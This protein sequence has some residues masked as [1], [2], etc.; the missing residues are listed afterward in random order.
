MAEDTK[1]TVG[2]PMNPAGMNDNI[3]LELEP[4]WYQTRGVHSLA[5]KC[6][7]RCNG[8]ELLNKFDS[9]ILAIHGGQRERVFVE[10]TNALYM[11]DNIADTLPIFIMGDF[12]EPLLG[13]DDLPLIE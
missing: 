11:F 8:K 2:V 1:A 9:P 5:E 3:P 6:L 12:N 13:D 10:T 4:N 7:Q